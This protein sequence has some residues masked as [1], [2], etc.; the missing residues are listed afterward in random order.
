MILTDKKV[1][2][3]HPRKERYEVLDGNGLFVRVWASLY[4]VSSPG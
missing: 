1:M 3:L 4:H 2:N